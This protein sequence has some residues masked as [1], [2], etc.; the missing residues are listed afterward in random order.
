MDSAP[1]PQ[2]GRQR[3]I[4]MAGIFNFRDVGGYATADG[5]RTRWG[6]LFR[7]ATLNPLSADDA[8]VLRTLELGSIVDLRFDRERSASPDPLDALGTPIYLPL[9]L[10][11]DPSGPLSDDLAAYYRFLLDNAGPGFRTLFE[12]VATATGPTLIHCTAGKDRTGLS[13]ALLLSA[14]GVPQANIIEDYALTASLAQPLFDRLREGALKHGA[15][16]AWFERMLACTP[17]LMA[18]ALHYLDTQ[19]GGIDRYLDSIG[20]TPETVGLLKAKLLE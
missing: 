9:P 20:V 5:R 18:A 13:V 7:S 15:D 11:D 16:P 17:D 14:C 4:D 6:T 19:H 2:A 12:H 1:V 8:G 10:H 3:H